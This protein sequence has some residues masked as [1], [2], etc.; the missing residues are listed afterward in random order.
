MKKFHITMDAWQDRMDSQ[1][2]A[3]P[4]SQKRRVVLYSFAGYLLVTIAIIIQVIYE[5]GNARE[6]VEV[7]HISNP[8]AEKE[9]LDKRRTSIQK[10]NRQDNEREQKR[11]SEFSGN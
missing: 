2:R 6:S 8:V 10:L 11:E 1:W 7:E 9:T 3:L 5:V 4:A